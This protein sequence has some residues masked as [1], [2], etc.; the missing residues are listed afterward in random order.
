MKIVFF[1]IWTQMMVPMIFWGRF[2]PGAAKLHLNALIRI[3]D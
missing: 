2:R 1:T 3:G